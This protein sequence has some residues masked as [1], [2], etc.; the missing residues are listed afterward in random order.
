MAPDHSELATL[1]TELQSARDGVAKDEQARRLLTQAREAIR[2]KKFD[3]AQRLID[4]AAR[5]VPNHPDLDTARRELASARGTGDGNA[6]DRLLEE[7]REAIAKRDL[8]TAKRKLDEA[9]R[10]APNDAGIAALRKQIAD[11]EG[12]QPTG[13]RRAVPGV[14]SSPMNMC[15][16]GSMRFVNA[17]RKLT[18]PGARYCNSADWKVREVQT[19]GA[20]L[21]WRVIFS[22]G[23]VNCQCD[24]SGAA[25]PPTT[26]PSTPSNGMTPI[27]GVS[28]TP[29]N[30]CAADTQRMLRTTR[31]LSRPGRTYCTEAQWK[32]TKTETDG[33]NIFWEVPFD[34]GAVFCV[35]RKR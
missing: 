22:D 18:L 28:T 31:R 4:E 32:V 14:I 30:L 34:D 1:R 19:D 21:F 33:T 29:N 8:D 25:T 26:P 10:L 15:R 12:G 9:A 7:A 35:C 6:L 23:F 13:E 17:T 16:A 27:P 5:L 2:A 3:D 24:R 20:Q 11:L